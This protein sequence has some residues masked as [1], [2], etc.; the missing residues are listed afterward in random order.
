MKKILSLFLAAVMIL[1]SLPA[2]VLGVFAEDTVTLRTYTNVAA[3]KPV[4]TGNDTAFQN[5]SYVTD[6]GF[7]GTGVDIG[8]G[9]FTSP[10]ANCYVI[11]DLEQNYTVNGVKV[12]NY[13]DLG[14]YYCWDAYAS[15]DLDAWTL[16]AQKSS[17]APSI[18]GGYYFETEET[19]ARYIKIVGTY[20]SANSGYHFVE[21]EVY[22]PDVYTEGSAVNAVY[23]GNG[24]T[25][26]LDET[27]TL[28]LAAGGTAAP[29]QGS[30]TPA[31]QAGG[32]GTAED[33]YLIATA[34]DFKK[35]T[36]RMNESESSSTPYGA[37]LFFRQT[38]DIDMTNVEG[39]EGTHADGTAK[40]YF[41]GIYD[42]AGHTLTVKI[43]SSGQTSVFP[44]IYGAIINLKVRGSI[45]S[46]ASAQPIR[47]VQSGAVVANCVFEMTLTS[48]KGNGVSYSIYGTLFNVYVTGVGT[49]AV[50][51]S[52]SD[53]KYYNVFTNMKNAL[54][55]PLTHST[56]TA[57]DDLDAIAAAFNDRTG[58][59]FTNGIAAL[60]AN[61]SDLTEKALGAATVAGGELSVSGGE[62][63]GATALFE[64]SGTAEDPYLIA[65]AADFKKLTD[66]FCASTSSSSPYGA[67]LFFR[68]TADVDMTGVADYEG[69]HADGNAKCYFGGV[70]DGDGHT[71]TVNIESSGQ[72]SVFPYIYGA[73]VNLKIKG[74]I[75]SDTSAQPIRTVQS[76]AVVAN[77]VFEMTLT[78]SSGNGVSYTVYGTLYNVYVSG[79]GT[80]AVYSSG[81]DGK[82]Y[83]VFTNMK[84]S[85]GSPL[86][87]SKTTASDDLDAIAA[88]F[89]DKESEAGQSGVAALT[90]CS[91]SLTANSLKAVEKDGNELVFSAGSAAPVTAG[92]VGGRASSKADYPWNAVRSAIRRVVVGSDITEIGANAFADCANLT[93]VE[94]KG[95]TALA[96]GVFTNDR[97]TKLTT[98][99]QYYTDLYVSAAGAADETVIRNAL[100]DTYGGIRWKTFE[101]GKI[102]YIYGCGPIVYPNRDSDPWFRNTAERG[103]YEK[104][105]VGDAVTDLGL[106]TLSA[107]A[108]G[109]LAEIVLGASTAQFKYQ[110][111]AYIPLAKLTFL[112]PVTYYG[113]STT[114]GNKYAGTLEVTIASGQDSADL[115]SKQDGYPGSG[116][117]GNDKLHDA[118]FTNVQK[119]HVEWIDT[120]TGKA[121]FACWVADGQTPV[122][123]EDNTF[124]LD[125]VT[126]EFDLPETEAVTENKVYTVTSRALVN[127]HITWVRE[128]TS[129]VLFETDVPNGQT[130]VY[131]GTTR[132]EEDGFVFV[133]TVPEAEPATADRTYEV[134]F[135]QLTKYRITWTDLRTGTELYAEDVTEGLVPVFGG[136]LPDPYTE[137]GIVYTPV[138]PVV[139][140]VTG[141]ADYGVYYSADYD[142]ADYPEIY[143]AG[144]NFKL[145]DE[146]TLYIYGTGA[147][148]S[149]E[150]SGGSDAPWAQYR[151]TVKKIIV[152]DGITEIGSCALRD[153]AQ[154]EEIVLG[155]DVRHF[156]YAAFAIDYN[157][158]R[159]TF[160]GEITYYFGHHCFSGISKPLVVT[161]AAGQTHEDLIYQQYG[162]GV[163][164]GN[165]QLFNVTEENYHMVP[166]VVAKFV[167]GR[168][169]EV[170]FITSLASGTVPFFAGEMPAAYT[171]D[172]ITY[173]PALPE[174]T[175]ITASTT[176]TVAYTPDHAHAYG[177]W[178]VDQPATFTAAG[179]KSRVCGVCG[180]TETE[181]IPAVTLGAYNGVI[182]G[183]EG[184]ENTATFVGK[185]I[186]KDFDVHC[187]DKLAVTLTFKVG[188]DVV[189]TKTVY[190]NGI[191]TTV[192]G[193]ATVDGNTAGTQ[194]VIMIDDADFLFAITVVGVPAGSYTV[195]LQIDALLAGVPVS[196]FSTALALDI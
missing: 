116:T 34:E 102:L 53:G 73:I 63:G 1:G 70:Y 109:K 157:L 176:Y 137:D 16:I 18:S 66:L 103:K 180:H 80:K 123:G 79:V 154:L 177:D 55:S 97:I 36:E 22:S 145:L 134:P 59:A 50:Y 167:D 60:S 78:S 44:Y 150:S 19:E 12:A 23:Q 41:G 49:K 52:G 106:Y 46:D 124:V 42:G 28:T 161:Q 153:Y 110:S 179:S 11:V 21:V 151:S 31:Q 6:G 58:E 95:K 194:G 100:A 5:G 128:G 26:T 127:Y 189:K 88:A 32:S 146:T 156:M 190:I 43:E 117:A 40:R 172:G 82:Y 195:G 111:M 39:Y 4:K 139:A 57:S 175:A 133:A 90:A 122:F 93:T 75:N 140:P 68:Q 94:I 92:K 89:A 181:E 143:P 13:A 191:Y 105:V 169:G 81:T 86:T 56:T 168:T 183:E 163:A 51:S 112:A 20:H 101:D 121:V 64:G 62:F 15:T 188:E 45:N 30:E 144:I 25:G 165:D 164:A 104:A 152:S 171:E 91:A 131:N 136:T 2:M 170:L 83:N 33:P 166:R 17:S 129:T 27:G 173:T 77:C 196:T 162:H 119:H 113:H 115:I 148:P 193:I 147:I 192:R 182:T 35:L 71:L 61:C 149:Y 3:G 126:Y 185:L 142:T 114:Y 48:S 37:G 14:R 187:A 107:D 65:S 29:A 178:T 8:W 138:L 184:G 7:G 98:F 85:L 186:G 74:S 84:N 174:L 159:M 120:T 135:T 10:A 141:S 155:K 24:Y 87:H 72:T 67:G 125:N 99:G 38:A 108:Y 54:G 118:E 47:T 69:T 96:Q 9:S 76:G 160:L 158:S 130:P 132:I